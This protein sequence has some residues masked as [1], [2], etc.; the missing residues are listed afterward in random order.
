MIVLSIASFNPR[1]Q[2]LGLNLPFRLPNLKSPRFYLRWSIVGGTL[3]FLGKVLKD[4]AQEVAAIRIDNAGWTN[5]AI[6]LIVTLLAHTWSGLVWAGILR[7]LQ[8]PFSYR[9]ALQV[10]LKTN[11]A[12]Y[13][14]GNIWH[15]SGR[16]WAVT[17]AG[18]SLGVATLSVLLEPLLMAAAALLITLLGSQSTNSIV[19]VGSFIGICV[20]IHPHILNLV[21]QLLRRLKRKRAREREGEATSILNSTLNTQH[22]TLLESYPLL[23][24]L[25]ELGFLILRGTGFLFALKALTTVNPHSIP[26]LM[27]AFSLS[28]LLGLIVPGAPGGIGVFE[29]TAIA[30]LDKHFPAGLLLSVVAL[31]RLVSILAEAIAAGLAVLSERVLGK[32]ANPS[33]S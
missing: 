21:I 15:F 16:I 29:A 9:W 27:S 3:F 10:Y 11:I 18:G 31:F 6:A 12:K 2:L 7:S 20:A 19:Q 22:S 8:Q 5:L 13:L 33:K 23:P 17:Q 32:S 30:L 24:L 28:W 25:G 26:Q 14:P 4:R 1:C